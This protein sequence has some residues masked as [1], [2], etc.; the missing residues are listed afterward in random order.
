MTNTLEIYKDHRIEVRDRP[1]PDPG[2]ARSGPGHDVELLI[3]GEPVPH[4]VMADGQYF[5]DEN[6]YEWGEELPDL[7][8]RLIDYRDRADHARRGSPERGE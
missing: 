3:D 4:G 2:T 7:A 8:R 1:T 6:A 5:L